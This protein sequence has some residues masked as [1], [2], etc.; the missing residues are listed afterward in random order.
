LR[1]SAAVT[2]TAKQGLARTKRELRKELQQRDR[3]RLRTLK[4][5]IRRLRTERREALRTIREQCRRGRARVR[6]RA[7]QRRAELR[8]ELAGLKLGQR[9]VCATR[10]ASTDKQFRRLRSEAASELVRE[11]A[12]QRITQR[13]ESTRRVT[14]ARLVR[15]H[16]EADESDDAV[17]RNLEADLVPV[18]EQVKRKFKGSGRRSR[19]ETFLEWAQENPGE[20]WALRSSIADRELADLLK[21]ERVLMRK[22]KGRGKASRQALARELAAAVPF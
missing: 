7:K 14:A 11:R 12:D 6:E 18:W 21:E 8:R 16:R 4:E 22:T 1:E 9:G 3:A 13:A 2:E 20:V 19:T 5:T 15:A 17:A 10:L